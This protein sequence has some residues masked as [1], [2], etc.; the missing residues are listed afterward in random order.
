MVIVEGYLLFVNKELNKLFD[1]RIW[2][3][4]S[5]LNILYRRT[6]RDNTSKNIDYIHNT[7]I[8]E[9]KKY[10]EMQRR[11]ADIIIDGNKSKEGIIEE[12]EEHIKK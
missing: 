5:D 4:V 10:E 9:S 3:D 2:V 12:F 11:E 6:K 1:K 8:P 7:V